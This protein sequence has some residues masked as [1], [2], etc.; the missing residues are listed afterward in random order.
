MAQQRRGLGRGLGALIP[1]SPLLADGDAG[2]GQ[3]PVAGTAL[4]GPAES[5]SAE[6]FGAHYKEIPVSAIT[7]NP[8]QPR[9]HAKAGVAFVT[10]K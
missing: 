4:V 5:P 1:E 6:D 2:R 9:R 10:A 7:P 8:R 3:K